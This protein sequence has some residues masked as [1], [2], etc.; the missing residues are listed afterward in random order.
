MIEP[1]KQINNV[2]GYVR[3]STYEQASNGCSLETQ[4]K[5][6]EEFVK[7][8][9]N[10][11]VDKFFI[12]TGVSGT[13]PIVDRPASRELTDVMD[14]HDIIVCTRL[15]RMSR[16]SGDLLNIIPVLEETGVTLYF[17][18]QFGDVPI[19]YPKSKDE[20]G[21]RSKFDM[22]EMANR[23]MLMVLSAVSEIEHGNIKDRFADG[24]MDWASKGHSIGGAAPFGF[25]KQPVKYGNKHRTKLIPNEQEQDVLKTIY[26][27]HDSGLGWR[28]I[29]KQVRSLHPEYPNF[30]YQKVGKILG[31]KFQGLRDCK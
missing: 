11:K 5:L 22:N 8:K 2:Y 24:K 3:V 1:R 16:S 13:T 25:D 14:E 28:R 23:I 7:E 18:Q 20:S 10:R 27:L 6:I 12:E 26:A 21:L 30:H 4:Q 19:V 9:Y 15:D 29:A 17:C 31:R